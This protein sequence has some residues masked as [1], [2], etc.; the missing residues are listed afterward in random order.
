MSESSTVRS[1]SNSHTTPRYH[2][3]VPKPITL[4]GFDATSPEQAPRHVAFGI[5]QGYMR[6]LSV[7]VASL[8]CNTSH[9]LIVHVFYS[10]ELNDPAPFITLTKRFNVQI[11]VYPL[12]NAVFDGFPVNDLWTCSIYYRALVGKALKNVTDRV[13]YIDA[14]VICTND[15][16]ELYTVDLHGQV[17]G[18]VRDHDKK[19]REDA[20]TEYGVSNYFNSGVLVIDPMRWEEAGIS[21]QFIDTL[22]EYGDR[23]RLFDQDALNIVLDGKTH[24]LPARFNAVA[25]P[26]RYRQK[27][28]MPVPLEECV[29]VH[30]IGNLKPWRHG[31]FGRSV[32]AYEQYEAMTPWKEIPKDPPYSGTGAKRYA[33]AFFQRK[34]WLHGMYWYGHYL[35][36]KFVQKRR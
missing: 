14:D 28:L 4:G 36:L 26:R 27:D 30:F 16:S 11:K 15:F 5:D 22:R 33:N 13:V 19:T 8:A 12:D 3:R 32:D 35:Q 9:P 10:G 34:R 25:R 2:Y 1:I 23:L 29:L 24:F 21:E 31:S 20:Q 17:V 7:S 18:A 6:G